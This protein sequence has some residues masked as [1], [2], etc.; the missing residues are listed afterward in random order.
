[1]QLHR[2]RWSSNSEPWS[3]GE[4]DGSTTGPVPA[5]RRSAVG[6]SPRASRAG[7]DEAAIR[8]AQEMGATMGARS[9]AKNFELEADALGAEG[10]VPPMA[11]V[12]V[13]GQGRDWRFVSPPPSA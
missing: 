9:Y 2:L 7:G 13:T 11:E 3:S 5:S 6:P 8:Q 12:V 10:A 1:M 4:L